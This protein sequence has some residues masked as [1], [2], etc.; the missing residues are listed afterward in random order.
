[1]DQQLIA[2]KLE[3]LRRC[4][5]RVE[6]RLPADVQTLSNDPDIQ[7]IVVLNLTRAVQ[8]CVDIASHIIADSPEAAPATMGESFSILEKLNI[9]DEGTAT[10]MK[11]AV[12]FRNVA[13]H[14]YDE[15]DW[16][17]VFAIG[18][19]HLLVFRRSARQVMQASDN[20]GLL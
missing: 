10:S 19:K 9:I 20:S 7:D 17:I 15:I 6:S 12:G 3:S 16:A 4:V 5:L 18:T 11:K 2:Q 8:L 13:V 14:D 1:M